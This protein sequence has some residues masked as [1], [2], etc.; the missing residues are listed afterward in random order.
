[1]TL[2]EWVNEGNPML[3][4]MTAAWACQVAKIR[5]KD[6]RQMDLEDIYQIPMAGEVAR[7]EH[8]RWKQMNIIKETIQ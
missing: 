8:L 2:Q 4:Q 5:G 3:S 1:M 7:R 6:L